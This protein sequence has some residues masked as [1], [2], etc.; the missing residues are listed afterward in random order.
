MR[1]IN[2]TKYIFVFMIT[3]AIFFS[4][5]FLSGYFGGKKM[6]EL[7]NIEDKISMNILASETQFALLSDSS[8]RNINNSMLSQELNSLSSKLAYMEG[9]LGT[10]NAEVERLKK[11]YSLLQIKDYLLLKKVGEKCDF[12]P[13]FILYFYSNKGDCSDCLKAGYALTYLR[14]EYPRLRIYSFDYNLDLSTV[15]TLIAMYGI[16]NDLPAIVINGKVYYGFKGREEMED[17]FPELRGIGKSATTTKKT[18]NGLR[19]TE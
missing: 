17:L 18:K 4:A 9:S 14:K 2:W 15:K 3:G 7:K 12:P 11:Y 19:I 10:E 5:V 13:V 6:E 1:E 16:K 8:C